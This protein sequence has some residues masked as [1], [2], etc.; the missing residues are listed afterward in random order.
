MPRRVT[1]WGAPLS[2]W[3]TR[4]WSWGPDAE[5]I[6]ALRRCIIQS[7]R[8]CA[9]ALLMGSTCGSGYS[10]VLWAVP[11]T[12]RALRVLMRE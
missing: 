9:A 3:Q 4:H 2:L 6:H 12:L 1:R 11:Q 8:R 7:H 5:R 10:V